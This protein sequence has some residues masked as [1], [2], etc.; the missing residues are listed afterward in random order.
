MLDSFIPMEG[1]NVLAI[2]FVEMIN[3]LTDSIL[4]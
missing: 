1:T 3:A 4:D 2:E